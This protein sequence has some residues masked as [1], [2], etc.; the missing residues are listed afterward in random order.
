M[1]GV[2][3][4]KCDSR[5]AI[6]PSLFIRLAVAETK[7]ILAPHQNGV[8]HA[9]ITGGVSRSFFGA[10][11]SQGAQQRGNFKTLIG[12]FELFNLAPVFKYF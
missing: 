5:N 4:A 6:T 2:L 1:Q 9:C 12:R 11:S 8:S 7:S 3:L 10:G